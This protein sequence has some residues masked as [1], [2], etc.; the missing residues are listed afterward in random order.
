MFGEVSRP[1]GKVLFGK[2]ISVGKMVLVIDSILWV[3]CASGNVFFSRLVGKVWFG[4]VPPLHVRWENEIVYLLF[5]IFHA[6]L[7]KF[8]LESC[9]PSHVRWDNSIFDFWFLIFDFSRLVGKVLFGKLPPPMSDETR[10]LHGCSPNYIH[11]HWWETQPSCNL[12]TIQQI[13]IFRF[14]APD[15]TDFFNQNKVQTAIWSF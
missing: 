5:L 7:A 1:V 10:G 8:Y 3:R 15:I 9:P 6:W 12:H 13:N 2:L 4:K 11:H 14:Q